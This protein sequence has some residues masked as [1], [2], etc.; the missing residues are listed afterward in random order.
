MSTK[1][2]QPFFLFSKTIAAIITSIL[3]PKTH[4]QLIKLA[5]ITVLIDKTQINLLMAKEIL[6]LIII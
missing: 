5:I 2:S 6:N 4:L 1:I 3:H